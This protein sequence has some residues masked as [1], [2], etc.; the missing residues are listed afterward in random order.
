MTRAGP[1][2]LGRPP[3]LLVKLGD[4]CVPSSVAALNRLAHHARAAEASACRAAGLDRKLGLVAVAS[5]STSSTVRSR[6]SR[7]AGLLLVL[8]VELLG[9]LAAAIHHEPVG[10]WRHATSNLVPRPSMTSTLRGGA[11]GDSRAPLRSLF[12]LTGRSWPPG[13]SSPARMRSRR[14]HDARRA[15]Q[16]RSLAPTHARGSHGD[17]R[18]S[19]GSGP[20][21][22]Q[23][24]PWHAGRDQERVGDGATRVR[25]GEAGV[26]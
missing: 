5:D 22:T 26:A 15:P 12:G 11:P 13:A 1:D 23:H 4:P 20:F 7:T 14:G 25:R 21:V 19:G 8:R 10:R 9:G 18:P 24:R 17:M 2:P 16:S 6:T 3:P